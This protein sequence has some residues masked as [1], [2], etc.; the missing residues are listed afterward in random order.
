LKEEFVRLIKRII[1][2][3][4]ELGLDPLKA[5]KSVRY[6]PRYFR[7]LMKFI[8]QSKKVSFKLSPALNDFSAASGSA[9]GHYFWQDLICANWIYQK[10][11]KH[12]FDVGSRVD[13]FIAHLTVFMSVNQLDIRKLS[14]E[15]P[16]LIFLV[17]NAQKPLHDY[18]LRFDSVSSLHSIEHFGLGRYG[19]EIDVDGHTKG[20][21]NISDC[22]SPDGT[23]YV[24]FPIG[25]HCVE[26]NSQRV[27]HP[28][29]PVEILKNF[30]LEEFVLIPWKGKPIYGLK[31]GDVD[32][33]ISGQAGLYRFTRI[34]KKEV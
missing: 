20:L 26:F 9:D 3:I 34:N 12:H 1:Y 24:S 31:P 22:V 19:D 6:F 16:N 15:V 14:S 13:G 30:V 32:L 4:R 17:G 8:Y 7:D 25:E 27:L 5:F 28:N 2:F 10:H 23:F 11:P 18:Q 33:R 29:W 21:L